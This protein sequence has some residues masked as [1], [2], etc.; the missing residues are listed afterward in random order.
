MRSLKSFLML[1]LLSNF[2]FSYAQI[3]F[4]DYSEQSGTDDDGFGQ[5]VLSFD[6][7]NDGL[8]DIYLVQKYNYNRLYQN[9]GNNIFEDVGELYGVKIINNGRHANA[10]DFNNDGWIDLTVNGFEETLLFFRNDSS[11]FSEIGNMLG[12]DSMCYGGGVNWFDWNNDGFLDIFVYN[13]GWPPHRNFFFENESTTTFSEISDYIGLEGI[14]STLT[15]ASADYDKDGDMDIFLGH[16]GSPF[17]TGILYRNDG[18]YFTNVSES[19]GLITNFYTWGADWGD[20]NNDGN[21]D[22][23]IC[24][25][26][27]AGATNQ[28]FENKGDGTFREIAENVGVDDTAAS[29]SCAWADFDNDGD[30]DLYVSNSSGYTDRLYRNDGNIF[31]DIISQTGITGD[32]HTGDITC[33][34]FNNDGFVDLYLSNNQTPNQLYINNTN[35]TNNW[36]ELKLVGVISNRSAIGSR[37]EL[38]SNGKTQTRCIQGG[39]GARGRHSLTVEFGLGEADI[40]DTIEITWP[41]GIVQ[42]ITDVN[43]NQ[44]L[45]IIE[46]EST[47]I[48]EKKS[49]MKEIRMLTV[50]PNPVIDFANISFLLAHEGSIDLSI[51]DITGREIK[52]LWYDNLAKGKQTIR[53]NT[54]GFD[55][56]IYFY[57]ITYN[58]RKNFTGKIIINQ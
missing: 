46:D 42:Y 50:Y 30:L 35:N 3:Q 51:F 38:T 27:Y 24:N 4:E 6:F 32:Q 15:S 45:T 36:I 17:P 20:F 48:G 16:Q 52:N 8:L 40:I 9:L 5:G 26:T 56:G 49:D 1:I 7:N 11:H 47:S 31:V 58:Q 37:V 33:G 14:R 2:V 13:D 55:N 53:V 34:D 19:S 41:S 54:D 23:Y 21:L 18:E 43:A 22:L 29:F 10:G 39:S 25:Y 28:L 57:T 44:I 12:I